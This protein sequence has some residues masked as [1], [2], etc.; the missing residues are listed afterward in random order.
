MEKAGNTD[1]YH[2]N[3][4]I[5]NYDLIHTHYPPFQSCVAE[6]VSA[7][8][9]AYSAINNYPC[10]ASPLINQTLRG[11]WGYQG[12]VI[13]DVGAVEQ[14]YETHAF[15]NSLTA[16]AAD[17]LKAGVDIDS[18]DT[19]YRNYLSQA[20]QKGLVTQE[21]IDRSVVV[22]Y[23]ERMKTGEWNPSGCNYDKLNASIDVHTPENVALALKTA[24]ESIVLLKNDKNTLPLPRNI[25]VAVVG[26]NAN[27]T[28]TLL[29]IY[30]G[31]PKPGDII[32]P[33]A[34]ISAKLPVD[35]VLYAPGC[36]TV[37]CTTDNNFSVA[38]DAA[39]KAD[40]VV[41]VL[42][43]EPV[44]IEG[45]MQDRVSLD[46]PGMQ[47]EL[48]QRI[49]NDTGKPVVV[50][51]LNGGP[52]A[53]EW[54]KDNAAAIVEAWYGGE[55]AG[56][57]IAD[58]LFGDYNPGGRLPVTF[59]PSSYTSLVNMTDMRMRPSGSF[60]GRTYRYY[61]GQPVYSFGHG[62]SYTFFKYAHCID[63]DQSPCL[64]IGKATVFCVSVENIG[65]RHGDE[66][67]LAYAEATITPDNGKT[68]VTEKSLFGFLRI[69]IKPTE[70]KEA[71]FEY[72]P[73]DHLIIGS[74][75]SISI[76]D[77]WYQLKVQY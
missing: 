42:G 22:T 9:C 26:P 74:L 23:T 39:S 58:V 7:I 73:P 62:M 15:A 65:K 53:I 10:C 21:D 28:E 37:R 71:T 56:N 36:T 35:N 19:T 46:L 68:H 30:H 66:V 61:T 50:V 24:R 31:I 4:I 12:F 27:A 69:H 75:V 38:V 43:L 16:A 11:Q 60:P 48:V 25:K 63:H 2:F 41:A 49:V 6:N 33:L 57:A 64:R 32:S 5:D 54:L 55:Q 13:S 44:T 17:A 14:I 29:G 18:N 1:R 70:T 59:Y 45:E 34:G 72:T 40:V 67:V 47:N 76:G 77:Q 3:A 8:M 52:V 20:L 51:L